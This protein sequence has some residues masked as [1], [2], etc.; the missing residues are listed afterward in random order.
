MRV[1]QSML[2][3]RNLPWSMVVRLVEDDQIRGERDGSLS[4]RDSR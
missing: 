1:K 3:T 2:F 4:N